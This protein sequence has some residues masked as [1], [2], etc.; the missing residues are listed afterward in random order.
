MTSETLFDYAEGRRRAETGMAHALDGAAD[1]WPDLATQVVLEVGRMRPTFTS[2]DVWAWLENRG[3]PVP[4]NR[5]ALGP[6]MR[7]LATS[8][9]IRSTGEWRNSHRPETHT[10]P[11]RVWRLP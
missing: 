11:L 8:G 9:A 2:D 5:S 10:R 4:A 7:A 3:L 1:T 6:I